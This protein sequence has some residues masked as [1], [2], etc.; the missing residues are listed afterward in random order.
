MLICVEFLCESCPTRFESFEER[1][2]P[3]VTTCKE[4]GARAIRVPAGFKPATVWAAPVS[5]GK[6]DPRPTPFV[7]DTS[8]LADGISRAEWKKQRQALWRDKDRAERKAK[9]G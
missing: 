7:M 1:P 6:S 9:M 8:K 4:C 3:E 2:A 5:M